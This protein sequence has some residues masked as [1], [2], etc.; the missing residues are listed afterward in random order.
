MIYEYAIAP[1]ALISWA[2]NRSACYIIKDKFGIGTPRIMAD[3]PRLK[4]WRKN[5]REASASLDEM[6]KSRLEE[7]FKL[8]TETRILRTAGEGYDSTASWLK[9][10]ER[11]ERRHEFKAI[12]ATEDSANNNHILLSEQ[13]G[14]WPDHLWNAPRGSVV[15]RDLDSMIQ[16]LC[17]LLQQ[18]TDLLFIDPYFRATQTK[19]RESI[20]ALLNESIR[21][22]V[23]ENKKRI[24][25]HVSA[26]WDK[27][28]SEDQFE[29]DCQDKLTRELPL[30]LE[31]KLFRWKQR[32]GQ[33]KLR[34]R[35]ILT[36][37][38]G[39][40]FGT[41]LDSGQTGESDDV[42]LLSR[43][44]WQIRWQQY[45]EKSGAF[46]LER[47]FVIQGARTKPYQTESS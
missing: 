18:C 36:N 20:V 13:I 31:V 30:G 26:D 33:E 47:K 1:E 34:N 9:N 10:T 7:L 17:P 23:Y 6:S 37:L 24:E 25:I 28:P 22:P 46:R 44:Q 19:F 14:E 11:E 38:G 39:V 12:V 32:A 2:S 29:R 3:Y 16:A 35:Y 8:L 42:N 15:K 40:S 21:C 41:G 45:Q 27:C 43:D 4:R 5:F